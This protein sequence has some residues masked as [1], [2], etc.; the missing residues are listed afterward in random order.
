[1]DTKFRF[2]KEAKGNSEMDYKIYNIRNATVANPQTRQ[3]YTQ[4]NWLGGLCAALV[5]N[6][7]PQTCLMTSYLDQTD[8]KRIV[9]RWS[10]SG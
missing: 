8:F 6:P 4:N 1:M 2:E 5:Q 10:Y 3:E 9:C 7:L